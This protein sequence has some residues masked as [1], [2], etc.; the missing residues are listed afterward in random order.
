VGH[1]DGAALDAG[2]LVP[3]GVAGRAG[4]DVGDERPAALGVVVDAGEPVLLA[5]AV[6]QQPH[7]ALGGA[8]RVRRHRDQR[9]QQCECAN[10]EPPPAD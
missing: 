5:R 10:R 8:R 1:L 2:E 9:A 4:V 3:L 7:L 6:R